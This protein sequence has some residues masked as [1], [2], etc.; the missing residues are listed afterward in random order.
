MLP[1]KLDTTLALKAIGLTEKLTGSDKRLAVALLD[2]FNRRTGRCDPSYGTLAK[3]L[4]VNRRTV[5]R[6]IA[7]V[8][9]T[10]F[11]TMVR[12]GGTNNCNSYQPA[13]SFFRELEE[14]WKRERRQHAARFAGPE[15]SLSSG[16]TCPVSLG[17]ADL[18][19]CTINFIPLTSSKSEKVNS[20]TEPSQHAPSHAEATE[21]A[22]ALGIFGARIEK[23]LGKEVYRAWFRNVK[24][25]GAAGKVIVLSADIEQT[26]TR[27]E[28][29]YGPD[30]LG[31]FKPEY[32]GVL[33]VDVVVRRV[34]DG[35]KPP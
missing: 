24:F 17:E 10:G 31:C 26:R 4:S 18:Q 13:W 14:R 22:S 34:R 2:H 30:I 27:I 9:K 3:L 35:E 6:G 25:V 12:H 28:Q 11:F 8:V 21:P 32:D 5:G 16:Q 15:M 23:R 1:K 33:R 7:R 19:T 29:W 20:S